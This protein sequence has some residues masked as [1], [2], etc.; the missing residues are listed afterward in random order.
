MAEYWTREGDARWSSFLELR[1][2]LTLILVEKWGTVA[3][4]LNGEDSQGRARLDLLPPDML[5]ERSV[6]IADLTINALEQRGWIKSDERTIQDV[7]REA[8]ELQAIKEHERW[9]KKLDDKLK[10]KEEGPMSHEKVREIT[11]AP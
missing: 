2:S 5:V 1:G 6:T 4:Y 11:E 9:E 3:G 8:G 10:K 7:A